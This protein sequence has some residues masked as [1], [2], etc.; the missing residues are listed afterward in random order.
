MLSAFIVSI[1]MFATIVV[2]TFCQQWLTILEVVGDIKVVVAEA[3]EFTA[4]TEPLCGLCMVVILLGCFQFTHSPVYALVLTVVLV[5]VVCAFMDWADKPT[6]ET[7]T[8]LTRHDALQVAG[9]V[10]ADWTVLTNAINEFKVAILNGFC[11]P[12][13]HW[14]YLVYRHFRNNPQK[15]SYTIKI[16]AKMVADVF[17]TM[18]GPRQM[19]EVVEGGIQWLSSC[20]RPILTA[21]YRVQPLSRSPFKCLVWRIMHRGHEEYLDHPEAL[22][23]HIWRATRWAIPSIDPNMLWFHPRPLGQGGF[24]CVV[25]A[26]CPFTGEYFAVKMIPRRAKSREV[27]RMVR[28]E[29]ICMQ[30]VQGLPGFATVHGVFKDNRNFYIVMDFGDLTLNDLPLEEY[31]FE[32]RIGFARQLATAVQTMHEKGIVHRDIKPDNI[33][34]SNDRLMVVDFGLAQNFVHPIDMR[35]GRSFWPA[36]NRGIS[37]V[38]G[39]PQYMSPDVAAGK[40]YSYGA[41]LYPMGIVIR[42]LLSGAHPEVDKLALVGDLDGT[43]LPN[44]VDHFLLKIFAFAEGTRRFRNWDEING[45]EIWT[46]K[47]EQ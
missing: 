30:T 8:H 9:L 40:P 34:I 19:D 13:G 46:A 35:R 26:Y 11:L 2:Q 44:E 38:A 29:V 45:H 14:L 31:T 43:Q 32:E 16:I 6:A 23:K 20:Y 37:V 17:L 7:S 27:R 22:N 25:K 28:K 24:G 3:L 21:L 36:R 10:F 39:S 33:L 15:L 18:E 42:W 4:A 5:L 12:L 1:Q 47:K 41:D